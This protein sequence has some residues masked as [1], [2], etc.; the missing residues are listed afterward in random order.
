MI[1]DMTALLILLALSVVLI[2]ASLRAVFSDGL[3][4]DAGTPPRS[5]AVDPD[6]VAPAQ[7]SRFDRAA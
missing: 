4:G 2:V 7:R 3:R 6:F 5:H 1:G